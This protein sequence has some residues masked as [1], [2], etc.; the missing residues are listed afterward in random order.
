[1]W[2]FRMRNAHL[3]RVSHAPQPPGRQEALKGN[4]DAE[5]ADGALDGPVENIGQAAG[6]WVQQRL[7]SGTRGR[8]PESL[9]EPHDI[10]THD[11]LGTAAPPT[12]VATVMVMPVTRTTSR[13][14]T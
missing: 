11:F 14:I 2:T 9:R 6:D 7:S 4:E 8:G 3:G 1:M 12:L 10:R 5:N 13:A